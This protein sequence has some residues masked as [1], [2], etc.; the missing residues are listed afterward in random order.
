METKQN[1]FSSLADL[2]GRVE[3]PGIHLHDNKQ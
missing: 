3:E 2:G 1:I